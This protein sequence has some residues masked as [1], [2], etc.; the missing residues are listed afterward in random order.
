M[1]KI[2][3]T[4][5]FLRVF[6]VEIAH[7]TRNVGTKHKQGNG[8]FVQVRVEVKPFPCSEKEHVV[9]PDNLPQTLDRDCFAVHKI[10]DVR[11]IALNREQISKALKLCAEPF[12]QV[13]PV[14][15]T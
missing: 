7:V 1:V 3:G 6:L 2:V 8:R 5:R 15:M 4:K 11:L 10:T 12:W 14:P 9:D 13:D